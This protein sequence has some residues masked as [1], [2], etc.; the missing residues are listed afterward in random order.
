MPCE[1]RVDVAV[2][3]S[4]PL[5][6]IA[7]LCRRAIADSSRFSLSFGT[8]KRPRLSF[9]ALNNLQES[10]PTAATRGACRAGV[11]IG[12]AEAVGGSERQHE[13][14]RDGGERCRSSGV[15]G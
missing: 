13:G 1:V 6:A 3:N 11:P 2:W 4:S 9:V 12:L 14:G 10:P 5:R 7:M 15:F 8:S